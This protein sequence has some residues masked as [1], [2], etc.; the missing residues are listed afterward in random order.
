MKISVCIPS[1]RADTVAETIQSILRQSWQDWEVVV[2][3]Q[4]P[5]TD[6]HTIATKE[7][8][9]GA[10]ADNRV[11]Y[12]HS[13]EKGATRARNAGMQAAEGEILAFIDD[14]CEA[15]QEWL[16]T[17]A[18]VFE[19]DPEI[20]LVGGAVIAPPKSRRGFAKCPTVFPAETVYEPD[21]MGGTPPPG[22]D[23]IS[24]NVAIRREV[25]GRIGC[26][27]EY[28]GPGTEFPA[29]DD[30]DY[31]LRAESLNIKMA[32]TPKAVV[33]HTYGYRYNRQLIQHIRNYSY[34]N[35]GLAGK[36]TLMGDLRGASWLRATKH[37][38]LMGWIWPFR[39]DKGLRGF[40]G[41]RLFS[42]AYAHCVAAYRVENNLLKPINRD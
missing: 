27:D 7:A 37:D 32:V 15:D 30:T 3:G 41:W 2:I 11:R 22:W 12:I 13:L 9:A 38:R 16:S 24:S 40:M 18:A 39:P 28:L 34:A 5:P 26:W 35:G 42:K 10:T 4:G 8:V 36:L 21:K 1:S 19:S 14:D 20:G 6:Q 25:A 17:I 33:T 31:L 23:W 29:A